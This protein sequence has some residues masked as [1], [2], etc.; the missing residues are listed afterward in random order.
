M[1]K[2]MMYEKRAKH[3]NMEKYATKYADKGKII[4]RRVEKIV[5]AMN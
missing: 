1:S 2:K 3:K 4:Q 5:I